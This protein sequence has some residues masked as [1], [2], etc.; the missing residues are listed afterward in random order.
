MATSGTYTFNPN[1]DDIIKAA[2]RQCGAITAGETPSAQIVADAS[3]ALNAMVKTWQSGPTGFHIWTTTE[4]TLF[5]QK[6]QVSYTLSSSSTDHAAESFVETTLAADA[7]SGASTITVASATG[8]AASQ[9]IGVELDSGSFDWT[10]ISGTPTTTVT[11]AATLDS[12]ASSGNRVVAYTTKIVRPL[13]IIA[14][15]RYNFD[16]DQDTEM[17]PVSR[18]DYQRLTSKTQSGTPTQFYYDPRGGANASGLLYIWPAP[19][20][21]NDVFKFTWH[22]PIQD[23]S[24]AANTSDLPQEWVEALTFNLAVRLAPEYDVPGEKFAMLRTLAAETLD[25]VSGADR[26]PESVFFG[27]DLS[28][29]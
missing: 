18:L 9:Y 12:A 28:Y 29:A 21:V 10:T 27:V 13:R 25:T 15:R 11:L 8:L 23:F 3:D 7:A 6:A 2:L 14:G 16:S 22:R 19:S 1:R 26:E 4:A 24:A 20:N 17:F 5:L